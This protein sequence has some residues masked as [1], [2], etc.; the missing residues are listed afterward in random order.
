MVMPGMSGRELGKKLAAVHP[1]LA[2]LYASGYSDDRVGL[3]ELDDPGRGFL[4]KPFSPDELAAAVER[5][6]GAKQSARAA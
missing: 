2:V 6:L 4:Q 3:D 5:V 1:S